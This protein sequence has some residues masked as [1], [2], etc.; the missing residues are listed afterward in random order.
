MSSTKLF[1]VQVTR[2]WTATLNALV[3]ADD[4]F[5]AAQAAKAHEFL[6]SFDA[7]DNDVTFD[8]SEADP[9]ILG[10]LS[11]HTKTLLLMPERKRPSPFPDS[12]RV[13][14]SPVDFIAFLGNEEA[15]RLR[16]QVIENN[17]GQIALP[18]EASA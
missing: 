16:I 7:E 4:D 13:V 17:N 14:K 8:A 6:D 11:T 5:T 2:T 3:W 10:Q 15:E 9:K 18:I 12:W 1:S